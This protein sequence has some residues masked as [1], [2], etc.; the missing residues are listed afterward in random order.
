MSLFLNL[1]GYKK[2]RRYDFAKNRKDAKLNSAYNYDDM[3]P[4]EFIGRSLSGHI[5][6]NQIM[7]HFLIFL[8]DGVKNL[9]KGARYLHNYKNYT[10]KPDDKQTR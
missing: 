3:V 5:Q 2:A 8:E 6:R 4:G 10:V 1:F 9:L 7:Q